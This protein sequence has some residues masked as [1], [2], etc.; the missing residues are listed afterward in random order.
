MTSDAQ[1]VYTL[2]DNLYINLTNRC[3][4]NC[5]FCIRKEGDTVG[6]SDRLWLSGDEPTAAR[7][8][9]LLKKRDLSRYRQVVF[10]GYGEPT[11]ALGVLLE[12]ASWLK[13][14]GAT[15][16]INT[17]GLADLI[18]G[19]PVA[20]LLEGRVDIVSVSLN[21]ATPERYDEIC[22]PC[23]EGAFEVLLKFAADCKSHVP[24]VVLSVVD[25]I[26]E[27]EI[28]RSRQIAESLGVGFRVRRA[29]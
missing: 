20:P 13:A 3:P 24:T 19:Q 25:V 27:E 2:G 9:E 28:E 10:C 26:G 5:A 11:E 14:Q 15:V 1:I 6:D 18:N 17:N 22:Q 29:E 7:V 21:E 12:V 8:I 16:R 23:F 4:C